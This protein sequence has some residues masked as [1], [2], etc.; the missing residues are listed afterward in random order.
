MKKI[1]AK[2]RQYAV[3]IPETLLPNY[4][5]DISKWA[6][7]ACD[8]YTSDE[9]YWN[10]VKKIVGTEASTLN[11][12]LPE[13]YLENC[14]FKEKVKNINKTLDSYV[15]EDV[16]GYPQKGFVYIERML[17][18]KAIR[19][20]LLVTLDLEQ[21]DYKKGSK[22]LIRA[23]EGT[24]EDRLPP[25]VKIRKNALLE[26]SHIMVFIDDPSFS[27]IKPF[28]SRKHRLKCLYDF[29]LMK[30]GGNIKGYLIDDEFNYTS[31]SRSLEKLANKENYAKKYNLENVSDMLLYAVGD[32]NH[33]LAAAK[34]HWE[35][36]KNDLKFSSSY[37]HP[38]RYA[39]V[40]LI[41][42]HQEA[43]VFEAI[44]R[45]LFNIK[46]INSFINRMLNYFSLYKEKNL[47]YF[48][49]EKSLKISLKKLSKKHPHLLPFI[50]KNG[51]G[52]IIFE[53]LKY[54]LLLSSL[55]DF[56]KSID[57]KKE[58]IKIDYIHGTKSVTKLGMKPNNIGFYFPTIDKNTFF[59]SI[60]LDGTLPRKTFSMGHADEKRFYLEC[61]SIL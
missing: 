1:E 5:I 27:L 21:Y 40:E 2:L 61:R 30:D 36:L 34:K 25:R 58:N 3:E 23:T 48:N 18:N 12:T 49:N 51:F 52:L 47:K 37:E 16:F 45:V 35:D 41:N 19:R 39:L 38:A 20:G 53:N 59:K 14:N 33:S 42:I 6:V 29:D 54:D 15:M 28:S 43:I 10:D 26:T 22:S 7:I 57:Y 24:M 31:I 50:T 8:Q 60:I 46:D 32:G 17:Q 55:E 11:I 13:I 4:S 44:H 56:F 9:N